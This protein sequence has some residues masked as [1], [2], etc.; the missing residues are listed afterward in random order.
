MVCELSCFV[1]VAVVAVVVVAVVVVFV[2]LS[3]GPRSESRCWVTCYVLL[4]Q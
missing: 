3:L 4:K 1:V 2:G